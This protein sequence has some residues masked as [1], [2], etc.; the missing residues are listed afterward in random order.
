M[1]FVLLGGRY[2]WPAAAIYRAVYKEAL[3]RSA[4]RQAAAPASRS[5]KLPRKDEDGESR[6]LV[7]RRFPYVSFMLLT[8]ARPSDVLDV[9]TVRLQGEG[10]SRLKI[11]NSA[12]T[13]GTLNLIY[14]DQGLG[15]LR[16]GVT[17][18]IVPSARGS[19]VYIRVGRGWLW[20]VL[21]V[22]L[23]SV[24]LAG[25]ITSYRWHEFLLAPWIILALAVSCVVHVW[26]VGDYVADFLI[27]VLPE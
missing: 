1:R 21:Q 10:A 26:D 2:C 17:C 18:G 3:V 13:D 4:L 15:V 24:A 14:Q 20:P 16:V 8:S 12:R 6:K 7:L 22:A 11:R 25:F 9:V 5:M 19:N 23:T 27:D